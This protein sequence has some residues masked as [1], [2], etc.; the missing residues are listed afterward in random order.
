[1]QP[2]VAVLGSGPIVP[3]HLRALAGAGLE[4]GGIASMRRGS[5]RVRQVAKEWNVPRVYEVWESMLEAEEGWDGVVIATHIDGL[6]PALE[7]ALNLEDV[8]VLVEKPVA[9]TASEVERFA[10]RGH[11]RV[12]VNYHRRRYASVLRARDFV[13]NR[14]P[15]LA[16]FVLP[17]MTA[18]VSKYIGNGCHGMD[19]IR[20]IFGDVHLC[21]ATQVVHEGRA[22]GFTATMQSGRGDVITV[23]GN[24]G[25][26]ASMLAWFDTDGARLELRPMEMA[27]VYRGMKIIEPSDAL[28]VRQYVPERADSVSVDMSDGQKPGFLEQ[29][30]VFR[31]LIETGQL[32]ADAATLDDARA[33]LILAYGCIAAL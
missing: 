6:A 14:S 29:A 4:V 2:R 13:A 32:D 21:D 15:L 26:P 8:P 11:H 7:R 27:S 28:P 5:T 31:Q 22:R 16:T 33:A 20:F 19:T 24:W 3:H 23:I 10:D 25:T 18:D 12:L 17:E 30:Q 9:W 1:M